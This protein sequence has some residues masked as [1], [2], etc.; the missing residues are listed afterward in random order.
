MVSIV[1]FQFSMTLGAK[2]ALEVENETLGAKRP[3]KVFSKDERD[4]HN[5]VGFKT[6]FLKEK[7]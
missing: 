2:E 1:H 4:K 3:P 6:F 5:H 7:K